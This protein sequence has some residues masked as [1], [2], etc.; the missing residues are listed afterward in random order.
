[1]NYLI[2]KSIIGRVL[3][4]EAA[5]MLL[6]CFTALFIRNTALVLCIYCAFMCIGRRSSNT[7]KNEK[8]GFLCKGRLCI[9]CTELDCTEF[10]GRTSFSFQ[11]CDKQ[12][13]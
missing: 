11:R 12:S 13:H 1:M 5:F 9:G 7:K 10:Y 2:V 3:Y 6:P 8:Y 4:F